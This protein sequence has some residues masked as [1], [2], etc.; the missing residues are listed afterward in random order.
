MRNRDV[1]RRKI[2]IASIII[3]SILVLS[4]CQARNNTEVPDFQPVITSSVDYSNE[5]NWAYHGIGE[6]QD[7]DVFL[8]AP[9][10]FRGD[11]FILNMSVDDA[12][13]RERF[14]GAL[15]MQR[16]IYED[17]CILYAPFYSQ[18]ALTVYTTY[19][20]Y[21][22]LIY[23]D[24]AYADIRAA[25]L[26]Y[27]EHLNNNRP[28]VLAGFSQG[29]DMALRLMKEFWEHEEYSGLNIAAYLIGWVITE[30]DITSY[31]YLKMAD[32]ETDIG[33]IISFNTEAEDVTES[34]IVG[35]DVKSLGINPLNWMTDDTYAPAELNKGAVF[36]N[37]TGE[38]VREIPQLTGAY[39]DPNRGTLKVTGLN[40]DD[41]PEILDFIGHGV[42]HV[43]DYQFF[44]RNLQ[45]N[46]SNRVD[47][48]L[49]FL[50]LDLAS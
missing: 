28:F 20:N 34:F 35:A 40:R 37:Y 39:L 3:L 18:A 13:A 21:Q 45:D 41:Y 27:M 49:D 50:R 12:E 4:A 9:T 46:V 19:E 29:A 47:A 16:G 22:D 2:R 42:Y 48:F 30:D 8:I 7:A 31:P 43:Y 38:I 23:F 36:T 26:Y 14:I 33:Y 17:S 32:A 1:K 15:N 11:E 5:E 25:F 24:T 6:T 10:V 44:Y